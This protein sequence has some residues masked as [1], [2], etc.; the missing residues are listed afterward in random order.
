MPLKD[1]G[2]ARNLDFLIRTVTS[3]VLA[4]AIVGAVIY[5]SVTGENVSPDLLGWG[6]IVIGAYIAQHASLEGQTTGSAAA[7]EG[8][9]AGAQLRRDSDYAQEPP[10]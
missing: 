8:S 1:T 5:E 9:A 7:L 2:K 10:A 3:A 4:L 6:G